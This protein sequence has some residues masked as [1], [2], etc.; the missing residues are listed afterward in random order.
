MVGRRLPKYYAICECKHRL[1]DT[2][3]ITLT[4][5]AESPQQASKQLH[6]GYQIAFVVDML[7]EDEYWELKKLERMNLI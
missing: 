1:R 7:T 6:K 4:T 5:R 3:I 2:P